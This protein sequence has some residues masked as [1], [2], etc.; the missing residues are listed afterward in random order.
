RWCFRLVTSSPTRWCLRLVLSSPTKLL[1]A[2]LLRAEEFADV[3]G[4]HASG[5]D[6][7][8]AEIGIF[9]GAAEFR[10]DTDAPGGF[11]KDIGSGLLVLDILAGDDGIEVVGDLQ[12]LE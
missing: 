1:M 8:H 12:V 10:G 11:Q 6:R 4:F 9:V 3:D 7:L 5:A 2:D